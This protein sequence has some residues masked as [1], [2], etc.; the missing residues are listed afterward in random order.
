[1]HLHPGVE[2]RTEESQPEEMIHMKV[3]EQH[4]HPRDIPWQSERKRPDT[5]PRVEH[6]DVSI[7]SDDAHAGRVAA[8]PGR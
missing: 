7:R 1:V 8:V 3:R 5:R 6:E 2:E 4:V